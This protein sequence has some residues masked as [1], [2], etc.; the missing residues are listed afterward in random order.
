LRNILQAFDDFAGNEM[1][2][3]R[4]VQDY[5]SVYLDLYAEF[6][7]EA[8][9]DKESINDD[10]IFE[11][12]LIKQVEI[13]VDYILM[14]VQRAREAGDGDDI[15]IRATIT[16]AIDASP[17]LRNKKHLI[18]AFVDSLSVDGEVDAEWRAFVAAQRAAELESIIASEGL[19][20]DE[21]QAFLDAAFRD[22]AIRTTGTAITT[23][24]PP[25]SRFASDGGHGEKKQRV[26]ARLGE[27]FERF[28]GLG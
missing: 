9:A 18:E 23:V 24:L 16:R 4:Q 14:L 15:E 22:G 27:F 3:A 5:Q 19:R 26:I 20:P 25:V 1:L 10:V 8:D 28:L 12:E 13:N 6:R 17:S 2:T 11:I 7:R 21:T